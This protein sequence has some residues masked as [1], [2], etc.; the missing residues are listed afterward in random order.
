MILTSYYSWSFQLFCGSWHPP[1]KTPRYGYV[2]QH[3]VGANLFASGSLEHVSASPGSN[4]GSGPPCSLARAA[5]PSSGKH[6][7]PGMAPHIP[8][9]WKES[10]SKVAKSGQF[11][12][13]NTFSEL[14][15]K[16]VN[17][18]KTTHRVSQIFQTPFAATFGYR[19]SFP[20]LET[21]CC[22]LR[23]SLPQRLKLLQAFG[24]LRWR[25]VD[26]LGPLLQWPR[27]SHVS[28]NLDSRGMFAPRDNCWGREVWK[29]IL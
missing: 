21:N 1:Q 22:L 27:L 25:S 28:H 17:I 7:P 8:K 2:I 12:P 5:V 23:F 26:T 14:P 29:M 16:S 3:F 10:S 4:T 18:F 20:S 6:Q 15:K 9:I 13:L 24:R 19:L 11:G